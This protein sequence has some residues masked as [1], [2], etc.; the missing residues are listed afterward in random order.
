MI[1]HALLTAMLVLTFGGFA[2]A[3]TLATAPFPGSLGTGSA[4]CAVTN[5][6]T[7]TIRVTIEMID[8][9]GDTVDG[10]PAQTV[11]LLAGRTFFLPY[12]A[13]DDVS[14]HRCRFTAASKG[15]LRGSFIWVSSTSG[16]PVII[17][18]Q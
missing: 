13:L 15:K 5:D 11:D 8:N 14:P 17:P 16:S 1:R 4:T 3:A 12:A 6:G 10:V 18:A 2:R 9:I 7:K